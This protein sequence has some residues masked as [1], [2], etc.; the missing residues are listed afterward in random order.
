MRVT[1]FK[2]TECPYC[3]SLKTAVYHT[4]QMGV[5]RVRYHKCNECNAIFQS[6]QTV[7]N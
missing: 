4:E 1:T 7:R 5:I 6:H 3:Q 2:K